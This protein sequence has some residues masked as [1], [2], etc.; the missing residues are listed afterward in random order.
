MKENKA[1]GLNTVQQH[2]SQLITVKYEQIN[3][4]GIVFCGG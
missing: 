3:S 1:L 4:E 2:Q